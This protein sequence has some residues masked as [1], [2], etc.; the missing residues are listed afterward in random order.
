MIRV[1]HSRKTLSNMRKRASSQVRATAAIRNKPKLPYK[2]IE[3]FV[4]ST[5]GPHNKAG[6][7]TTAAE[8][9]G[10]REFSP[11]IILSDFSDV[12]GFNNGK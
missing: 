2:A 4:Y 5:R 7:I 8:K 10:R 11:T 9:R 12:A 3:Q 6:L 1:A